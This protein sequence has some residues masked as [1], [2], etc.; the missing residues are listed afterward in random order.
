MAN[1]GAPKTDEIRQSNVAKLIEQLQ[2]V[3]KA[4]EA[5]FNSNYQLPANGKQKPKPKQF[6]RAPSGDRA[7]TL[8]CA[9]VR[10]V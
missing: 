2:N 8:E 1:K 10:E 3:I 9:R 6:P 4:R 5:S 7:N